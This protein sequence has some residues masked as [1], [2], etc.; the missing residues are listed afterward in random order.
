MMLLGQ[1][2][3][4]IDMESWASMQVF[5][6][7]WPKTYTY[8]A[9]TSLSVTGCKYLILISGLWNSSNLGFSLSYHVTLTY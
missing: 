8:A 2:T 3:R 1:E 4:R 7:V 9:R 5:H 6:V